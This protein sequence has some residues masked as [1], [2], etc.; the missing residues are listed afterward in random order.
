ME[1]SQE[2]RTAGGPFDGT[3]GRP[4]PVEGQRRT[5][6]ALLPADVPAEGWYQVDLEGVWNG[7]P[8][9]AYKLTP[10]DIRCIVEYF[11]RVC[12]ANGVDLP[13]DYEHQGVVAKLLGKSAESGGWINALEARNGDTELWAHIRWV[14]DALALI[15]DRKFRYLSSRLLKDYKDPVTGKLIPWVLDSVALTNRPF[16]KEL[17]AVANSAEVDFVAQPPS[18]VENTDRSQP[19]AA[20]PHVVRRTRRTLEEEDGAMDKLLALLA[21]AM[22]LD[23]KAVSNS[24]GVPEDA[25]ADVIVRALA[26]LLSAGDQAA[27]RVKIF[28][29]A[30]GVAET[31]DAP[32][33]LS[34]VA[35]AHADAEAKVLAIC[36]A[37]GTT[38]DKPVDELLDLL[39]ATRNDPQR[40]EA[41]RMI[42]NA[43][44]VEHKITPANRERFLALALKDLVGVR[45]ILSRMPSVLNS[46]SNP[47]ADSDSNVVAGLTSAEKWA[48]Q[49]HGIKEADFLAAKKQLVTV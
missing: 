37:L 24:L 20:V 38:P 1:T 49:Q 33:I 42:E 23:V 15:R 40:N 34:A 2:F 3:Q 43:V 27:K 48:C 28:A 36:N 9:G 13:V 45:K 16:K 46:G 26:T 32:A 17:P 14:D 41:E 12:R 8:A 19:R 44:S 5:G 18:A 11:N 7:H 35:A 22:S 39:G 4:E 47:S 21:A 30:L 10:A 31:A 29:N 25:Q 6:G